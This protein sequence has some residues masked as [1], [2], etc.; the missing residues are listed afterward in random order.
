MII[1]AH[2]HLVAPDTLYAYRALLLANGGYHSGSPRISDDS[3]AEA[4][5]GNVAIMDKVGTDFQLLSPRPFHLGS[6]MQPSR[7]LEPWIRANNDTIARTVALHPTRFAGVGAL[8]LSPDEPVSAAFAEVDRLVEAGFVGVLINPDLHEGRGATPTLGD[9]YWYPLW[10]RLV[11]HDLP[12]HIHSAG[13]YSERETYSE[14]F[15]TEE[16]IAV[17][18]MLR[19]EVFTDFPSLRVMISHG[20]GSVPYQIG[21]WQA[22]T[23]HPGLGG[24]PDS[25]RFEVSLRRF[26][27]DSVLHYPPSLELLLRLVGSDRVLFGTEKPGSGS[28][29]NPETG[30]DFDDIRPVIEG[31]GFLTDADRQAVFEDNALTVFP[32]L[33]K[34][35]AS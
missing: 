18:S 17:L 12:I 23:L 1:D 29:P 16:S 28:A 9:R 7:M 4:A 10:E 19:S 13:C 2:A 27:F 35:L 24:S 31:F 14:H 26:W 21:R 11:E 20:G 5:A 25:E 34:H 32:A 33:K 6:S 3:L 15:V 8:P 22:E 30:R